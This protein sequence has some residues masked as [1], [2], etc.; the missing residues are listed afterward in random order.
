[1]ARS[2]IGTIE[3]ARLVGRPLRP[4]DEPLLAAV[5]QDEQASST[6]GGLRTDDEVRTLLGRMLDHSEAHGF[7]TWGF[8]ERESGR[9]VGY[10]GLLRTKAGGELNVEIMYAL[11]PAFWGRAL[12]TEI[13]EQLV[14]VGFET[15][16][17]A[18]LVSYTVP[19]NRPSRRVMEKCGFVFEREIV[20]ASTPHVLY[21]LDACS[22]QEL[23][24]TA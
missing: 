5:L 24:R 19:E 22:Q 20:Y 8:F 23:R 1:M 4:G 18:R 3:T 11:V 13:A 7:G 6:V 17:F 14:R 2:E 21:R 10:G 15:L 16:G 12:A 9:Y